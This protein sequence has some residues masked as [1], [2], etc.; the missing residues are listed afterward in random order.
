MHPGW[1]AHLRVEK[2][3]ISPW[4]HGGFVQ[5]HWWLPGFNT[6]NHQ[7]VRWLGSTV[8]LFGSV[9][10]CDVFLFFGLVFKVI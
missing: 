2:L 4:R 1:N 9:F 6:E 10:V 3:G 7:G 8:L 5:W